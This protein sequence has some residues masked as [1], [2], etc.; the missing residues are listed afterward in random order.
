M[1]RSGWP[2]PAP[3]CAPLCPAGA[4]GLGRRQTPWRASSR[5][6][7]RRRKPVRCGPGRLFSLSAGWPAGWLGVRAGGVAGR[8]RTSATLATAGTGYRTS[9]PHWS[10]GK[11]QSLC[12]RS[13]SPS[14]LLSSFLCAPVPKP[15]FYPLFLFQ[16]PHSSPP[17][18]FLTSSICL[19]LF[20]LL[21]YLSVVSHSLLPSPSLSRCFSLFL[22]PF[23]IFLF[24][25][26]FCHCPPFCPLALLSLGEWVSLCH[27]LGTPGESWW[28]P[29]Y[30]PPPTTGCTR[31]I[32]SALRV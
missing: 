2:L 12:G 31:S 24:L 4:P 29:A 18:P 32:R 23:L 16:L 8:P 22:L 27:C 14:C 20:L 30:A 9:T 19:S 25:L 17:P 10:A 1:E 6:R 7:G 21:P 5:R 13:L 11:N 28:D 3:R 26:D 15:P